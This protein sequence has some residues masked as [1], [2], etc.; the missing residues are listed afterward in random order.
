MDAR[1]GRGFPHERHRQ[2]GNLA[3]TG[4]STFLRSD[5]QDSL[6]ATLVD[7]FP[8]LGARCDRITRAVLARLQPR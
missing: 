5:L 7:A 4:A 3:R 1:G 8:F 6:A 2:A